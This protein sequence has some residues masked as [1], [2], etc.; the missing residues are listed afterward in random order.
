MDATP[1]IIIPDDL[2][3]CRALIEQLTSTVTL[4]TSTIDVLRRE[5]QELEAAY[6]ELVQRAFRHRS[7]RYLN[8]PNQL[9]LDLGGTADAA[10]AVEGLTQAV[11]EAGLPVKAHTRRRH[12]RKPRSE[13]LPEHLPRYEVEARVPEQ[14]KHCPQ[15]GER[16]LIGYDR[17]E[18]LE[19]ERP[20]LRV[21]VT[22]YPK[23]ACSG[24]ADCGI[25]SPDVPRAWWRAIATIRAWRRRSSRPSTASIFRCIAS[26]TCSRAAAGRRIDR[27]C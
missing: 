23:Y 3:G 4:Q 19:F 8:D 14:M 7:E 20:R 12:A 25:A 16:T 27:P 13:A 17:V 5:K 11:E 10:D 2:A 15:H 26:R 24:H 9:L 18:K 1:E 6:T 21:R 22:R